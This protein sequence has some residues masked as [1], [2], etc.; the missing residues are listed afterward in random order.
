VVDVMQK[1]SFLLENFG[2]HPPAAGLLI[3]NSNLKKFEQELIR[4]FE[5]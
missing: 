2:G 3:K 5:K 4:F 1:Y